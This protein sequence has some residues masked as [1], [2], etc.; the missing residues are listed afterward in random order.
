MELESGGRYDPP[1]VRM[2]EVSNLAEGAVLVP[3]RAL[4]FIDDAM[5][6]AERWW[7]LGVL[8]HAFHDG[9]DQESQR[10]AGDLASNRVEHVDV[11]W[12]PARKAI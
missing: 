7:L 4:V 3:E 1:E 6:Q 5:P 12:T 9:L 11:G 2:R 10:H 8:R